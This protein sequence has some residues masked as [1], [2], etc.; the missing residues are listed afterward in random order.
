MAR[1]HGVDNLRVFGSVA[2]GHDNK[3]SDLDL[4]VDL[5]LG[6]SL[7]DLGGLLT[8]LEEFLGC[9][10]DLVTEEGLHWY[11]RESILQEARPL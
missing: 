1:R 7:L 3:G 9:K 5:E 11:V 10:V 8:E 6:R 2:R 4:L